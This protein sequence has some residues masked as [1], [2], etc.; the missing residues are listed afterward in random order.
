MKVTQIIIGLVLGMAIMAAVWYIVTPTRKV[1]REAFQQAAPTATPAATP[2][3]TTGTAAGGNNVAIPTF[4]TCT[5]MKSIRD[6]VLSNYE[7]AKS[8][9]FT[10]EQLEHYQIILDTMGTEM[11][12][13]NCTL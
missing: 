12:K 2:A 8:S 9:G 6:R 10:A 1:S 11:G 5:M 7:K 4:E 13:Q 3:T